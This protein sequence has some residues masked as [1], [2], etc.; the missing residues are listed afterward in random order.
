MAKSE[1]LNTDSLSDSNLVNASGGTSVRKSATQ[2]GRWALRLLIGVLVL[3]GIGRSIQ[4]AWNDI[5]NTQSKVERRLKELDDLLDTTRD[6]G[7]R[8][9]LEQDKTEITSS[10]M[11]WDRIRIFWIPISCVAGFFA[12]LMPGILW[13]LIIRS[14]G[15]QPPFL[16]TQAVYSIGSLGKYV[17]GKAMVLIL[18]S[19]GMRRWDIPISVSVTG[20]VVETLVALSTAGTLAAVTLSVSHPPQWLFQISL[21]ASLLSIV[22]VLPPIFNRLVAEVA[23]RKQL[24][25]KKSLA[26]ANATKQSLIGWKRMSEC[27]F[28]QACGW[29]FMGT[30]LFAAVAAVSPQVLPEGFNAVST[31]SMSAAFH[32]WILC[33]ATASLA[34]VIGFLSML[35]GGAGVRELIVTLLLAPLVGYAPALAAAVLYRLTNL[36]SELSMA[37][38]MTALTK[39]L[40]KTRDARSR[41]K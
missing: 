13:W 11:N 32:L 4:L 16:A 15:I 6:P 9:E 30:S 35:P 22:P 39:I 17:P 1:N 40:V 36:V 33:I 2:I 41:L 5:Q 8:E 14:F 12:I 27:W 23:K 25:S 18:R 29:L 24:L 19:A 31:S 34:F 10:Q 21:A 28:L 38:L 7:R 20:V 26:S 37:G 3:G